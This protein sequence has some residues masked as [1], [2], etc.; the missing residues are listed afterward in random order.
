MA[1]VVRAPADDG[2]FPAGRSVLRRVMDERIVGL[3][4][5]PRAL[6]MG[7]LEPLAFIG[8]LL[9]SRASQD[10]RYYD[11]LVSTAAMFDAVIRGSRDEA[12]RAL[13]R[14]AGMHRRVRGQLDDDLGPEYPAGTTYDAHDP[15]LSWF[16][17][18]VLCDSAFALH[19]AYVRPLDAGERD[20][21]H[22][23][24][25]QFG[26]LFGMPADAATTDWA[27]FRDRF[28]GWL[29]SDR[30]H[31][32]PLARTAGL[33]ALQWPLPLPL[34]GINDLTYLLVVG[35][36]PRR[37][38]AEFGLRWGAVHGAA[39][40][41]LQEWLRSSRRITPRAIATGPTLHVGGPLLRSLDPRNRPRIERA[42]ARH[43]AGAA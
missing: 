33:A 7:A 6:V 40:R 17:M 37:V 4:Y 16:T 8:T 15:W 20:A 41:G 30:P 5:G 19:E 11:R 24:W 35:T 12:D 32:L 27:G 26:Q 1:P 18:A 39:H 13:R 29:G 28:D 3:L 25:V 38:R 34:R 9:H 31:L 23:D 10:A 21:F 14:V 43:R 42:L 36:L 22:D 2:Y